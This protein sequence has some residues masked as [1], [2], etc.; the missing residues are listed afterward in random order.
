M[1]ASCL[2]T[3]NLDAV[4]TEQLAQALTKQPDSHLLVDCAC[5]QSQR[6]LGV[7]HVIS[8]LL[9]LR[10]SGASIWLRNINPMLHRC[11]QVLHLESLFLIS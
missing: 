4:H 6:T 9:L 11:L 2:L 10:Q 7:N 5:L 3:V 1:A 8:Q